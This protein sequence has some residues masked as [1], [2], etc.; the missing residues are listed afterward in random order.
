[1]SKSNKG[2]SIKWVES[3]QKWYIVWFEH[4][5]EYK[6]ST[7]TRNRIEADQVLSLHNIEKCDSRE[8]LA[9]IE[10]ASKRLVDI[11]WRP[12]SVFPEEAKKF[13]KQTK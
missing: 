10:K 5:R 6:K 1:M 4:G 13:Q 7:G 3:R 9:R 11:E 2:A 8:C 12:I